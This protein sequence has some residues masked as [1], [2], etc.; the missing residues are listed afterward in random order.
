MV[1]QALR[2]LE[3]P[4]LKGVHKLILVD[5]AILKRK[6][7]KKEMAVS[8]GHATGPKSSGRSGNGT[9]VRGQPRN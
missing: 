8:G 4:G 3:R 7:S 9:S 6:Q 2:L 1:G 5:Q